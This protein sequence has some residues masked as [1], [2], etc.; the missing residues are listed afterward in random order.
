MAEKLYGNRWK[1][2]KT[3]G[4]GGQGQVFLV[5]DLEN[6]NK[7]YVLKRLKN[8]ERINRFKSEIEAIK[9]LKHPNI[10]NLIDF[11]L[12]NNKPYLVTDY[13]AGGELTFDKV[14]NLSTIEKLKLFSTI[15]KAI[16]YAH[17]NGIIH[18]DIKPANILLQSDEKTPV[19]TDFGICFNTDEGLERLTETIE[20]VGARYYMAPESADGRAETVKPPSDVYS[21]GKLLYWMFKGEVFD[22]E[23]SQRTKKFYLP[24]WD[25]RKSTDGNDFIEFIYEI[26]EQ[27]IVENPDDRLENAIELSKSI[28]KI[29]S[30]SLNNGRF[31]NADVPS[32][33]IFCGVGKYANKTLIPK[34]RKLETPSYGEGIQ[35]YELDY[36]QF[37][38][39]IISG[40]KITL[41]QGNIK[42]GAY[43]KYLV[44]T[45]DYCGNLQ[46]FKV[47]QEG[48]LNWKN[49]E[50]EIN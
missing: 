47:G 12:E 37:F 10:V 21:L 7:S 22:R 26:F 43:Q 29:I 44:L 13:C 50:P 3:L 49:V 2:I 45:C 28:D 4:E 30:I 15:C 42:Q 1:T 27:T 32:K 20:Q 9:K 17:E 36:G 11:D 35:S 38:P 18:R 39:Q 33:C 24:K 23:E 14:S 5:E 16:G 41:P 40:N 48:S 46:M 6:E 31:L 34:I 19:V 25:L 8:N